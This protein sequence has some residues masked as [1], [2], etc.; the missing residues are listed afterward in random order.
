MKTVS[1]LNMK[2][3]VGKTTMSV[4]LATGLAMSGQRTLLVDLDPQG[5][6]T[7]LYD[8]STDATTSEIMK[9]EC[10]IK[11]VIKEVEKNL[12][13]VPSKLDLVNTEIEIRMQAHAPQHNRLQKALIQ[14]KDDFDYCIVD[15]PPIINLLTVNAIIASDLI[16][17]PIKPDKFAIQGFAV[18]TKNIQ[19]IKENW[20]IKLD[21]KILFTIVNRNNEER[22]II[23]Q[24][25]KMVVNQ[26]YKTEIR[27]QPKP[28]A[29]ASARNKAVITDTD[30][31]TGVAE[32]MRRLLDEIMEG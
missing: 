5:N 21:W 16:I 23:S 19:E 11:D 6:T 18:T 2:G 14:I 31:K 27:S 26:A 24:L 25:R 9:G 7:S 22:E 32:D 4:N 29:G 13:I 1:L 17:I 12:S 30:P 8:V 10:S 15:C 28:I 20:D 3:G